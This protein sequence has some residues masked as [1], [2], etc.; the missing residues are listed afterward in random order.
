MTAWSCHGDSTGHRGKRGVAHSSGGFFF[1]ALPESLG[2][3]IAAEIVRIVDVREVPRTHHEVHVPTGC[4]FYR[5]RSRCGGVVGVLDSLGG[6]Y[7]MNAVFVA[8]LVVAQNG[9]DG[10]SSVTSKVTIK[11]DSCSEG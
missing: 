4:G 10:R 7:E 9:K 5:G 6:F 8:G 1:S 2:V 11:V 3:G